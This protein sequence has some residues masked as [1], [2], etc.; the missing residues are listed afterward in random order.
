MIATDRLLSVLCQDQDIVIV[1]K[2]G[3]FIVRSKTFD[4]LYAFMFQNCADSIGTTALCVCVCV[5]VCSQ[6]QRGRCKKEQE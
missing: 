3:I 5:C 6:W 1:L 4:S 2:T